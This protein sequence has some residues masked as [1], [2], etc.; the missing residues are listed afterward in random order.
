MAT[1][2]AALQQPRAP[3]LIPQ[4]AEPAGFE[5]LGRVERFMNSLQCRNH[6][7][8]WPIR[9]ERFSYGKE[10][11]S[12]QTCTSCGINRLFNGKVMVSGPLF[13]EVFGRR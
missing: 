4:A 9:S 13:R 2:T 11:D 5:L 3:F 10:Y 12:H 6:A 7:W 1:P 8:S